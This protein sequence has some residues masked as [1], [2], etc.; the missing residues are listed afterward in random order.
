V[1]ATLTPLFRVILCKDNL[2][3]ILQRR[4]GERAG[5]PRWKGVG[6]F[7]EREALLR[8]SRRNCGPLDDAQIAPLLALPEYFLDTPA[9]TSAS[10]E[11]VAEAIDDPGV[12]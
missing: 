2:Q 10:D 7:R 1:I 4:D 6:F 9:D 11:P 5:R 3:W 8:E 12:T